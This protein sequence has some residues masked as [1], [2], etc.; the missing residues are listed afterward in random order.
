LTAGS[1]ALL[2]AGCAMDAGGIATPDQLGEA[3]PVMTP[4]EALP[5]AAELSPVDEAAEQTQPSPSRDSAPTAVEKAPDAPVDINAPQLDVDVD[6]IVM[7]DMYGWGTWTEVVTHSTC[8]KWAVG[9]GNT[10]QATV[11]VKAG[12]VSLDVPHYP[13]LTGNL[14]GQQAKLTGYQEWME[15]GLP[16]SCTVLGDVKMLGLSI[17][18][19]AEEEIDEGKDGTSCKTTVDYSLTIYGQAN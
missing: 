5:V 12:V 10:T 19:S 16:V 6:T 9:D 4:S 8:E 3:A 1:L 13:L 7:E 2:M 11:E 17:S 14:S 18:G 15:F